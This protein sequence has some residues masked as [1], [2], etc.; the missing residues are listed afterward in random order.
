MF[1]APKLMSKNQA[2]VL[3]RQD[4]HKSFKNCRNQGCLAQLTRAVLETLFKY[5][6]L[7]TWGRGYCCYCTLFQYILLSVYG[8]LFYFV[9]LGLLFFCTARLKAVDT[10]GNCQRPV[11]S[12]GVSQHMHTITNLWKFELNRSSKLRDM[13]KEENTLVTRSCLRLDS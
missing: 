3:K 9:S 8:S 11:F 4:F 12:L 5:V 10:I 1:T 13:M 6:T 2:E 7:V